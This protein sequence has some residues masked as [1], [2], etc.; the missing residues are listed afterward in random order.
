MKLHHVQRAPVLQAIVLFC[1]SIYFIAVVASGAVYQY[2]HERHIPMLL[3]SAVLFLIIGIVYIQCAFQKKYT[4]QKPS[5]FLYLLIFFMPFIGVIVTLKQDFDF[6]SLAYTD[7]LSEQSAIAPFFSNPETVKPALENGVIVMNDQN[8]AAWLTELYMQLDSWIGTKITVSGSVWKDQ[9]YFAADEFAVAR[10]MMLCC[11]ADMQPVG[12]LA[13]WA[14][15]KNLTDNDWVMV[16]GTVGKK[17][18]DSSADPIIIVDSV[19]KIPRPQR[20]YL[21]P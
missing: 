11:A 21:Y 4:A 13:Q 6:S 10:M 7:S 3:F 9:D 19:K 1:F 2:V 17:Q 15:A 14:E 18:Y 5:H 16:S 8:F 20:E 12:F